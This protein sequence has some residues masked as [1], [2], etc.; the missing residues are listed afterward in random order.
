[1]ITRDNFSEDHVRKLQEKNRRDPLLIERTIFAFGLLEALV[2]VG[3]PFTF[4]GG[5]SLMLLLP[6]PMRL[7]TDIDIIVKPG[8]DIDSF[9]K[10]AKAIFPFKDGREQI[11]E[12]KGNIEKRHFKFIYDSHISAPESLYVLLDVLFEENHYQSLTQREIKNDLLMT[13]GENFVVSLP[14]IDCVLGDKLTAFAPHTTGIGF[15]KKNLEIMKQ[16]FD[17]CTLIDGF[18]DFD[19]VLKTYKRICEAEIAYR[20]IDC[21]PKKA[22]MDTLNAALCIATRGNVQGGDYQNYLE[23]TNKVKN[24]IF[25]KGFSMEKASRLAP[26]LIYMVACLL[27]EIPFEK[28]V[29]GKEYCNENIV[30][31]D[32][33]KLKGLRNIDSV[34]YSYIVKADRLLRNFEMLD[35]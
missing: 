26:K 33:K 14:T 19:C 24:H 7:S 6:K 35:V 11:R 21:T 13:E 12:K 3:L 30:R 18:S 23:G 31:P 27:V 28:V 32:F 20:E 25:A 17:I 16:F 9:I 22:L 8:T 1:M 4:K 29:E 2:K 15:G 5:T 34:G 10:K